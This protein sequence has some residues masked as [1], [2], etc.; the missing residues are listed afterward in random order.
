MYQDAIAAP[1]VPKEAELPAS[2][3]S[4]PIQELPKE[5]EAE[6]EKLRPTKKIKIALN[7]KTGMIV[8]SETKDTDVKIMDVDVERDVSKL[9]KAGVKQLETAQTGSPPRSVSDFFRT[10]PSKKDYPDYYLF[11]KHPISLKEIR[12]SVLVCPWVR[13]E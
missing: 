2:L 12:V 10:L 4:V 8:K 7:S 6:K 11:I 5:D 3:I 1:E 13:R 9:I